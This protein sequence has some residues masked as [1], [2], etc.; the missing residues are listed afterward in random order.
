M[1][2][3]ETSEGLMSGS[4]GRERPGSLRREPK[5][6]RHG[7][8]RHGTSRPLPLE[9]AQRPPEQHRG[10]Y[11]GARLPH[12]PPLARSKLWISGSQ[13]SPSEHLALA[14]MFGKAGG[15][16]DAAISLGRRGHGKKHACS[17]WASCCPTGV[18]LLHRKRG[19]K[20]LTS[21]C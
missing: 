4:S 16:F 8:A 13:R 17:P 20:D 12:V 9:G 1:T 14:R 6:L 15:A 18:R 5:L 3:C 21:L 11:T 7:T 19:R 2:L 10:R